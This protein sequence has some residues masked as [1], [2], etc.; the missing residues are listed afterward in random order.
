MVFFCE[1]RN[2]SVFSQGTWMSHFQVG[3]ALRSAPLLHQQQT[4]TNGI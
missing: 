2:G 3:R 1:F 4:N